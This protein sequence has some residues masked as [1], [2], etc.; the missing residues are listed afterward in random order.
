M[1]FSEQFMATG[2]LFCTISL[3]FGIALRGGVGAD[4][5]GKQEDPG[6]HRRVKGNLTTG[7]AISLIIGAPS[8]VIGALAYIWF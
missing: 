8:L 4:L 3:I 1:Q 2:V 7:A 5:S 6:K